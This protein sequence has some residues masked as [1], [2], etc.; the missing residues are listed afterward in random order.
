[1]IENTIPILNVSN[2]AESI[3]FYV[4]NLGFSADWQAKIDADKIAGLSRDGCAIYLC[5]GSQGA[6]GGWIWLGVENETFIEQVANSGAQIV[7]PATNYPWAYELRV[8]DL[9]GN[10][11]RI[12]TEPR[13][14]G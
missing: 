1:M 3:E 7:Q 4:R 12:G 2:L 6:K 9:D 14:I 5:Q 10:V 11:I 8:Q 13:E